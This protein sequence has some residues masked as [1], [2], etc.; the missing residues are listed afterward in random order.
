MNTNEE[1]DERQ[2]KPEELKLL[3][4]YLHKKEFV[5]LLMLAQIQPTC[6]GGPLAPMCFSPTHE[7][8]DNSSISDDTERRCNDSFHED[9][10]KVNMKAAFLIN[11]VHDLKNV[12]FRN[13]SLKHCE[14]SFFCTQQLLQ[15]TQPF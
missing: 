12:C 3:R 4:T 9:D 14:M 6:G 8:L 10:V 7:E 5:K 2:K 15:A 13:L 1:S 11:V